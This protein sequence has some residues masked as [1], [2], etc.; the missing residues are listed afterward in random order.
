MM[1]L[2]RA[3]FWMAVV[4]IFVP[5]GFSGLGTLFADDAREIIAPAAETASARVEAETGL[6]CDGAPELCETLDNTRAVAGLLGGVAAAE[7]ENWL[8]ARLGAPAS[9]A[10]V[11]DGES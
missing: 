2:L 11:E 4:A 5:P 6:F 7:T 8:H 9:Q 3:L 10:P 1:F